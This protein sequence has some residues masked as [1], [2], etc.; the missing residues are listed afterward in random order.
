MRRLAL[1]ILIA[2]SCWRNLE[3]QDVGF[4]PYGSFEDGQFDS[5]NRENLDVHFEIPL[6]SVPGRGLDFSATLLNDSLIWRRSGNLWVPRVDSTGAPVIGWNVDVMSGSTSHVTETVECGKPGSG[7]RHSGYV[8][9]DPSGTRHPFPLSFYSSANC[10]AT[11][12]RTATAPDD[13]GYYIDAT[14]PNNPIV[15]VSSFP[16]SLRVKADKPV[17]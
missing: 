15:Y 1:T 8:F 16:K 3:A 4:P 17:E 12:P 5:I 9:T 11:D 10:G 14:G 6:L 7:F 13:S 2:A